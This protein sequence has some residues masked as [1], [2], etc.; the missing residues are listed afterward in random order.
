M[1]TTNK[2][3]IF[4]KPPALASYN[5]LHNSTNI[6]LIKNH[7]RDKGIIYGI[8]NNINN[9]CYIGSTAFS[10]MQ[11][12]DH[13][14]RN[15]SK[16]TNIVLYNSIK[17]YGLHN[18]TLHIFNIIEFSKTFNTC[19]KENFLFFKQKYLNMFPLKQKYQFK[20]QLDQHQVKNTV[21]QQNKKK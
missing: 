12:R 3:F 5:N 9:K 14:L 8:Q 4:N 20:L 7:Y 2:N 15:N 21:Q 11:I 1:Q 6:Q 18:F 10:F 19:R 13:L 17:K 16:H